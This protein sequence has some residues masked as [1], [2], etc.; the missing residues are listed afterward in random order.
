MN[1]VMRNLIDVLKIEMAIERKNTMMRNLLVVLK[2]ESSPI[3]DVV[4]Q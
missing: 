4:T 3:T 1:S 2:I